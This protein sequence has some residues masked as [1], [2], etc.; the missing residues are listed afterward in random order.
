[1]YTR[2]VASQN[3]TSPMRSAA[4]YAC[5]GTG[6]LYIGVRPGDQRIQRGAI[7]KLSNETEVNESSSCSRS[8]RA[9]V[10]EQLV[11]TVK[12]EEVNEKGKDRLFLDPMGLPDQ[13]Q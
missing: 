7:V 6:A 10:S 1:M 13:E 9:G 4:E 2:Y 11:V 12:V 8:E 3:V 5:P